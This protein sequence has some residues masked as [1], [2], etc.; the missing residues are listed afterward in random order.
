MSNVGQY[1]VYGLEVYSLCCDAFNILFGNKL[2]TE[3]YFDMNA[4]SLTHVKLVPTTI[5]IT[6]FCQCRFRSQF[7]DW[8]HPRLV[9][10]L[11]IHWLLLQMNVSDV[12]FFMKII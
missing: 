8:T 10:S 5:V 12:F 11:S 6:R 1:S 2:V 4:S 9:L 3:N 7:R